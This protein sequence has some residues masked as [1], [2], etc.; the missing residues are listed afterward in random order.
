M[1]FV[2]QI[3]LKLNIKTNESSLINAK[4]FNLRIKNINMLNC[5]FGTF[6]ILIVS[7]IYL[8]SNKN[9]NLRVSSKNEKIKLYVMNYNRMT[10]CNRQDSNLRR[11]T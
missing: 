5:Y 6:I 1:T 2:Y 9:N 4:G 7:N 11:F 8:E 10:S 3:K